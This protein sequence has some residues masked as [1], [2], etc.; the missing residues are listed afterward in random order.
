MMYHRF[1]ILLGAVPMSSTGVNAKE[2]TTINQHRRGSWSW[3]LLLLWSNLLAFLLAWRGPCAIL[4]CSWAGSVRAEAPHQVAVRKSCR[5]RAARPQVR[6]RRHRSLTDIAG[7]VLRTLLKA[8]PPSSD[9]AAAAARDLSGTAVVLDF[10]GL[11]NF[12]PVGSFYDVFGSSAVG[13]VDQDD[14]GTGNIA[15]E[16]SPSTVLYLRADDDAVVSVADGFTGISFQHVTLNDL[17]ITLYAGLGATGP[18]LARATIPR[19]V[20]CGRAGAPGCGDPSGEYGIWSHYAAPPFSGV[21]KSARFTGDVGNNVIDDMT[22]VLAEPA[23]CT[24]TTYWMWDPTTNAQVGE[25]L[26]NSASCISVPYNI[27]VRPCRA[28][29]TA[30]VFIS[31]KNATMGTIFTQNEYFAPFYLW[32]DTTS[33]GDVYANKKPLPKGAYWLYSRVDDVLEKITFTKTC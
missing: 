31:L 29:R 1:A 32:G 11:G 6:Y 19:T 5:G 33:T 28:P 20:V 10:E 23:S 4:L 3:L 14:G 7:Q 13:L 12:N 21:A 2:G 26:N 9:A 25:L 17:T 30:P 16:P 27:E 18:I 22:I 24:K 8:K 15:N